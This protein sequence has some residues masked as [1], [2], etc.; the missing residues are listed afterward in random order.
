MFICTLEIMCY[1]YIFRR[2]RYIYWNF[3]K[4]MVLIMKKIILF[5]IVWSLVSPDNFHKGS[6]YEHVWMDGCAFNRLH[7]RLM[8][9]PPGTYKNSAV[10]M[11]L[12]FQTTKSTKSSLFSPSSLAHVFYIVGAYVS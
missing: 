10:I 8:I 9:R 6:I 7:V 11:I 4:F 5:V 12:S 3:L 2:L 1:V